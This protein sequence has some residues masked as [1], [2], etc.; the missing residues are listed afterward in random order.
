[1]EICVII[2]IDNDSVGR[3]VIIMLIFGGNEM[4]KE[5]LIDYKKKLSKLSQ[6]EL[7]ERDLKY[8]RKL[9]TGEI[10]GPPVG[11]ASIDKSWL[12][13]YPEEMFFE[14][15]KYNK[16]ID[17]I[18][19][20]WANSMDDVMIHYYGSDIT[21]G[22]FFDRVNDVAKS[23][24]S[25]GVEKG[26]TVIT[27]LESVPE[28]ICLFFACEMIGVNVKNKIGAD[29]L[30]IVDV[31]NESNASYLFTHDYAS[32]GDIAT[33]YNNTKIENVIMINCV[34]YSN[35]DVSSLRPHI[36]ECVLSRYSKDVSDD[37][38]NINWK[39]FLYFG[40]RYDGEIYVESD[41]NTKLFSAY[42]SGST[43]ARKE[44]IHTSKTILEMLDQMIFPM[45]M[46]N[47]RETW[48]WPIYPPSLVAAIVAYMCMPLAQGKRVILDPYFDYK[49]IDLEIML[50]EPNSTGLVP[51]FFETLIESERIP[52]DYDMSYLKVL[53]FGAEALPRKLI[54]RIEKF[55]SKHNCSA[56]LNGG[57]GN[58]EGGS[59]MTIAFTNEILKT[60]SSGIPLINTIVSVFEPGTENELGYG[61]V[62][63]FCKAG[64]GIM[65]GYASE[66]DT[67]KT[68]RVH[69]D[70]KKWLHTG[71]LGYI[72]KE[73]FV[74]V[75]GREGI[76][77]YSDKVVYPLIIENKVS[78][79]EGVK[80]AVIV[81]GDSRIHDGYQTPYL[82]I[83]PSSDVDFNKLLSEIEL[84]LKEVLLE[85]EMPEDT[86]IIDSKPITHFKVD[87]KVLRREYN[88]T[89]NNS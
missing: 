17:Y 7:R 55:T 65:L 69:S 3:I 64:P 1:M 58:S 88:I 56:Q 15:K 60:G 31:I 12:G 2:W 83:V 50:Y 42:T 74:F 45:P 46:S 77:V 44:V 82:F 73:G 26:D 18:K 68:I 76:K 38:R 23:L 66:E 9:A 28:F 47:E 62:G 72:T 19:D 51:V 75:F 22:E 35:G 63:E 67:N 89:T 71:D 40:R 54:N 86:Y 13:F 52:D 33:I 39:D 10:Q 57:Y 43:G 6:E 14:R 29:A 16:I 41:E 59:E 4:T 70:G 27:N 48:F 21:A 53:G 61:E 87:R 34:E 36:R 30:E 11:Y 79:L 5:Q 80:N 8:I 25:F 37:R 24:K 85:E 84:M 20:T 49:D 81:S 78:D 32:K